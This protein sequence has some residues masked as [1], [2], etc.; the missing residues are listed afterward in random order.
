MNF[1]K[2]HKKNI[3]KKSTMVLCT[4]ALT[5][6]VVGNKPITANADVFIK[7]MTRP[8]KYK[9]P[10]YYYEEGETINDLSPIEQWENAFSKLE[11]V[12]TNHKSK[13]KIV[14]YNKTIS[15]S[16]KAGK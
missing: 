2:E 6:G 1:M 14:I 13:S 11:L 9:D 8:S 15:D 7:N 3:L 16:N 12:K 10:I 5:I 4:M